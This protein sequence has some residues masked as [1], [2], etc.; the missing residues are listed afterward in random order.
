MTE[1]TPPPTPEAPDVSNPQLVVK[2]E[3]LNID[4]HSEP[5]KPK[6]KAAKSQKQVPI[7]EDLSLRIEAVLMSTDRAINASKLSEI[8]N[9]VA[10]KAISQAVD[11]LNKIYISTNRSFR[12]EQ[13]AGGWQ[14]VT[15]PQYAQVLASLHKSRANNKLTAAALETLAII[16]YKQP[17][18]RAEIEAIRGVSTGET[19]RSLLERHLVK[20]VGRAEEIGR[21]MLYGTTKS[22]LEVFGLA[23]LKDLP[24]AGELRPPKPRM[25]IPAKDELD[26]DGKAISEGEQD[27]PTQTTEPQATTGEHIEEQKSPKQPA[28]EQV[29]APVSDNKTV[30]PATVQEA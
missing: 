18:L 2:D 5:S 28:I 17:V 10:T 4:S 26:K 24:N 20:I 15:L 9:G 12:I 7:P 1:Q 27:Q 13:L 25:L 22:F 29:T 3:A 23:S 19:V 16:A 14:I 6:P 8:F 30:P 21:P 11:A